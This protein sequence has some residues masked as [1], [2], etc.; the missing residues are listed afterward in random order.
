[1]VAAAVAAAAEVVAADGLVGSFSSFP[2]L[3]SARDELEE[4]PALVLDSG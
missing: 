4:V 2:S 1:M 3:N